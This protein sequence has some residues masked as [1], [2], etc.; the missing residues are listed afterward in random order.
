MKLFSR[1][2]GRPA[3]PWTLWGEAGEAERAYT[4]P[5][6]P[7]ISRLLGPVELRGVSASGSPL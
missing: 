5:G 7:L 3:A 2:P 1:N 6:Y 4:R